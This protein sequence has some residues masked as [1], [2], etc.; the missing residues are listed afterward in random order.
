MIT[1]LSEEESRAWDERVRSLYASPDREDLVVAILM[2]LAIGASGERE[3]VARLKAR[4]I[5]ARLD[6]H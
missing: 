4:A 6:T 2:D 1:I 5:L 3:D